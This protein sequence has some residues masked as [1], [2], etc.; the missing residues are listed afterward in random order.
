[1]LIALSR[2]FLGRS[3][4]FA[5]KTKA[6]TP[7]GTCMLQQRRAPFDQYCSVF[8]GVFGDSSADGDRD[9]TIGE[10]FG[11]DPGSNSFCANDGIIEADIRQN[12]K[13]IFLADP[14]NHVQFTEFTPEKSTQF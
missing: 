7:G 12:Q 8:S 3:K 14:A 10:G 11:F 2:V 9:G 5:V 6:I 4:H 1:M 13:E